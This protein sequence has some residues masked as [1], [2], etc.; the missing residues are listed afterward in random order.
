MSSITSMSQ[1]TEISLDISW[2]INIPEWIEV[3]KMSKVL[4]YPANED[5]I[6]SHMEEGILSPSPDELP[7]PPPAWLV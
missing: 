5:M 4:V 6:L 7:M 2:K 1:T 3:P